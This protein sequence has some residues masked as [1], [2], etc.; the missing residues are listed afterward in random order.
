[1]SFKLGIQ[2]IPVVV[3]FFIFK[4]F[5]VISIIN[6]ISPD[7]NL[8]IFHIKSSENFQSSV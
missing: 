2:A 8:F 6:R 5:I 1:M 3:E 4:T 7:N